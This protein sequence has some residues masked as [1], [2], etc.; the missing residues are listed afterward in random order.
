M[1]RRSH[2]PVIIYHLKF[3]LITIQQFSNGAFL[4]AQWIWGDPPFFFK[5]LYAFDDWFISYSHGKEIYKQMILA[6]VLF[7]I[8]I[9]FFI[10][11]MVDYY[12]SRS[13]TMWKLHTARILFTILLPLT[14]PAY[15]AMTGKLLVLAN[16][17][18]TVA[19]IGELFA[20]LVIFLILVA[21]FTIVQIIDDNSV[22][23][24]DHIIACWD[25][26]LHIILHIWLALSGFLQLALE[27]FAPWLKIAVLLVQ[28]II[29]FFNL[30]IL[31]FLPYQTYEINICSSGLMVYVVLTSLFSIVHMYIGNAISD[32]IYLFVPFI[33]ATIGLIP[34]FIFYG[35][36]KK[37]IIKNLTP[38]PELAD[39]SRITQDQKYEQ[40][41]QI[42]FSSMNDAISYFHIGLQNQCEYFYDFS[43]M[44][45]MIEN[46]AEKKIV[47]AIGQVAVLFP[48]ELQFLGY[49]LSLLTKL[50]KY[51]V[52]EH[53]LL[54]QIQRIHIV[55]QSSVSKDATM[56]LASLQKVSLDAISSVRGFWLEILNVKHIISFASLRL[57]RKKSLETHYKFL[58]AVENYQNNPAIVSEYVNFQIEV[59]GDFYGALQTTKKL[60]LLDQG[61]TIVVDYA[62]SS[63]LNTFPN[64]L[65]KGILDA[66]GNFIN[67]ELS[68]NLSTS[69]ISMST[70]SNHEDVDDKY[71]ELMN[72]YF[73]HPKLR[74]A[75]QNRLSKFKLKSITISK[76]LACL[77]ILST[78]IIFLVIIV[79]VL[80]KIKGAQC[81]F[82]LSNEM[83][84]LSSEIDFQGLAC[85]LMYLEL[86]GI[87]MG[88][89]SIYDILN[90][91]PETSTN[92]LTLL[93]NPT[94]SLV[95]RSLEMKEHL[96]QTIDA[97][98][99]FMK[100]DTVEFLFNAFN[101]DYV[102][103][104]KVEL[105]GTVRVK[106]KYPMRKF[107][108][109]FID[110]S[111]SLNQLLETNVTKFAIHSKKIMLATLSA[112][113]FIQQ[114]QYEIDESGKN[115]YQ[116]LATESSTAIVFVAVALFI[117]FCALRLWNIVRLYKETKEC[118]LLLKNVNISD[119][120]Q[121][122]KPINL[123]HKEERL[124][125]TNTITA[126]ER[127]VLVLL[128]PLFVIISLFITCFVVLW[129][130]VDTMTIVKD[131]KSIYDLAT[132]NT[133]R[134]IALS[135]SV[136]TIFG[137]YSGLVPPNSSV[138]SFSYYG[139]ILKNSHRFFITAIL[140]AN[141]EFSSFY[142]SSENLEGINNDLAIY[143]DSLSMDNKMNMLISNLELMNSTHTPFNDSKIAEIIYIVDK[144]TFND[145]KRI[146][147]NIEEYKVASTSEIQLSMFI[148][149]GIGVVAAIIFF[150]LEFIFIQGY[151]RAVTG[152][153]QLLMMLPPL[154][155][156]QSPQLMKKFNP[157]KE[158]NEVDFALTNE[159]MILASCANSIIIIDKD[160]TIQNTNI[161]F[162]K[163]TGFTPD[164]ALGQPIFWIIPDNMSSSRGDEALQQEQLLSRLREIVE[165]GATDIASLKLAIITDSGNIEIVLC[166]I[167]PVMRLKDEL[168]SICIMLK[169]L[170]N[171]VRQKR[172][173]SDTKDRIENLI[174]S[175]VPM[176]VV[177][178]IKGNKGMTLFVSNSA[179]VIFIEITELAGYVHTMSP[180]AL[181]ENMRYI[182]DEFDRAVTEYSAIHTLKTTDDLYVGCSGLFDF[183]DNPDIQVDQSISFCLDM[184]DKFDAI[185]EQ[186]DTDMHLRIGINHG[187][188][189][190]GSVLNPTSPSF[191]MLGGIIG[192]AVK[193]QSDGPVGKV[194]VSES[195]KNIVNPE[196]YKIIEGD[197]LLGARGR[198]DKTFIIQRKI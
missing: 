177:P 35:I 161:A 86:K 138:A 31:Y 123:K 157:V 190:A 41:D 93:N 50:P 183:K 121:S 3:L 126:N 172:L 146:Q 18:K 125:I 101:N 100:D 156:V 119:I 196:K 197:V 74:I 38:S 186:L 104:W 77:Q 53:F 118:T 27:I 47:F 184:I 92:E 158:L 113:R 20:F 39:S 98:N 16:K 83:S 94:I 7:L 120:K 61:K 109:D 148:T 22:I 6:A 103:Y 54:Y 56:R 73:E 30:Y 79:V 46:Y 89:A 70:S 68:S 11:I 42:S 5:I 152:I 8:Y 82:F 135:G 19:Y 10:Y 182:Y 9:V 149:L 166:T 34:F 139:N 15:G 128:Y 144:Y 52:G 114:F 142:F 28:A 117:I 141:K 175:L 85:S 67:S 169:D 90:I 108:V 188:P 131:Q 4:G 111:L 178:Q 75:L 160:F 130:V 105:D 57:I 45:Y 170:S 195:V 62:Y 44:R 137:G 65:Y 154:S 189:L 136:L 99:E 134:L 24:A 180:K 37:K 176:E 51:S 88:K 112:T 66:K 106:N 174:E 155:V 107:L 13:Y 58:D 63:L 91:P 179:T 43:F 193:M 187:G 49:I 55:R 17:E 140:N 14:L 168:D 116:A 12:H 198:P 150:L 143:I 167:I 97:F 81:L 60:F 64:Y 1:Y 36:R 122:I 153:T 173:I 21:A 33:I 69:A 181:M 115:K 194:Q 26:K 29:Y 80:Y 191:D 23:L 25:N 185:N 151:G 147:D 87:F 163:F 72:S 162:E 165:E 84:E 164:Q 159:Q 76:V 124:S 132:M 71:D 78:L 110:I 48:S 40:F 133:I 145:F 171:E 127:D 59:L 32:V 95:D 192:L 2:I 102:D 96:M 129:S